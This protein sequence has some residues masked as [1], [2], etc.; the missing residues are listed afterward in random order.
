MKSLKLLLRSLKKSFSKPITC[1]EKGSIALEYILISAFTGIL[2][3]AALAYV[4]KIVMA[5]TE[6]IEEKLGVS[7]DELPHG[8]F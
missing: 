4:N 1:D 5:K 6:A 7:F 2:T 3:I 8:L